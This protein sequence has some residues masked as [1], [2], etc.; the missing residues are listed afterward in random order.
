MPKNLND[1]ISALTSNS[2]G[3]TSHAPRVLPPAPQ[4]APIPARTGQST[5]S[6]SSS[7]SAGG[8]ASPLT[9][10]AY[11]DREWYVEQTISSSDGM[12]NIRIKPIKSLK[13]TDANHATVVLEFAEKA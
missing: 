4:P 11:A 3:Q 1:S 12:F 6:S 7:A 5:P 10:T 9:E 8:I 13:F 2:A